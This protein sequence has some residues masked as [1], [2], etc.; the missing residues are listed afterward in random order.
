MRKNA[1]ALLSV[2]RVA[3]LKGKEIVPTQRIISHRFQT[4]YG[5]KLAKNT[6]NSRENMYPCE[7]DLSE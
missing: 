5:S 2:F 3:L 1:L 4:E 7:R 6:F